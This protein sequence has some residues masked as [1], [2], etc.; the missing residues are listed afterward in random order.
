[1]IKLKLVSGYDVFI[2]VKYI[3]S[4]TPGPDH[5]SRCHISTVNGEF[6]VAMNASAVMMLMSGK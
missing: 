2:N 4:I 3:V 6:S 1:M 5:H